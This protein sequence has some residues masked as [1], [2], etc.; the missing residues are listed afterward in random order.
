M[1]RWSGRKEEGALVIETVLQLS[2][3]T[4]TFL[5]PISSEREQVSNGNRLKRKFSAHRR[6]GRWH[7]TGHCLTQQHHQCGC[8]KR[9]KFAILKKFTTQRNLTYLQNTFV[10]MLPSW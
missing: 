4:L 6:Q 5:H 9:C 1:R 10:K 2:V 8:R 3:P 7:K